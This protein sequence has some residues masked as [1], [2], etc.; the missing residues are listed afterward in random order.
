[1]RSAEERQ[2]RAVYDWRW[3]LNGKEFLQ[4]VTVMTEKKLDS[5]GTEVQKAS[6]TPIISLIIVILCA[7][8]KKYQKPAARAEAVAQYLTLD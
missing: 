3:S 5:D 4:T 8:Q 1:M 6:T 7:V 2:L